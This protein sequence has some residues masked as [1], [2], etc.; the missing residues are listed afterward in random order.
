M[1]LSWQYHNRRSEIWSVIMGDILVSLSEND[2]EGSLIKLKR[3][4]SNR[5]W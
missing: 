4:R 1:R 5:N 2:N 3:K